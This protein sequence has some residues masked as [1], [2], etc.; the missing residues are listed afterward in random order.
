MSGLF[1]NFFLLIKKVD[2]W[3]GEGAAGAGFIMIG[4]ITC[5][6][7]TVSGGTIGRCFTLGLRRT[8]GIT[9][10]DGVGK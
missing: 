6:S 1:L 5:I 3:R 7:F 2:L 4:G 9:L 10:G 8:R